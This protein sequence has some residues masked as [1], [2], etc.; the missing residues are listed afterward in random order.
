MRGEA[1]ISGVMAGRILKEF[2]RL[3]QQEYAHP[4]EVKA[5]FLTPREKQV[6]RQVA[7]GAADKEIATELSISLSTV[8]THMRNILAKLH[9]TS[10]HQAALYAMQQGLIHPPHQNDIKN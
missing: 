1:A 3:A 9:A 7:A 2:V 8:K 4:P 10:R 5:L 6:L